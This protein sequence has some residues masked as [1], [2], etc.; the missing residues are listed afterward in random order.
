[1]MNNYQ[2]PE[3]F[4]IGRAQ[5]IVLGSV[6]KSIPVPDNEAGSALSRPA[7]IDESDE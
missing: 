7:D 6:T 5:D 1:M 4:E 3:V 2:E